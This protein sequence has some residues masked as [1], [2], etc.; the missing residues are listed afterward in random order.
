M[1]VLAAIFT[2]N[3]IIDF[4]KFVAPSFSSAAVELTP[5]QK[6]LL[7]VRDSG[8]LTLLY[9]KAKWS[10]KL[11]PRFWMKH[12][13]P[14]GFRCFHFRSWIQACH[15]ESIVYIYK[16]YINHHITII[17]PSSFSSHS[18]SG[19]STPYSPTQGIVTL[20]SSPILTSRFSPNQRYYVALIL[21]LVLVLVL[22]QV[23]KYPTGIWNIQ[24]WRNGNLMRSTCY[25]L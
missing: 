4:C 6:R 11:S 12:L 3:T 2:I 10:W 22:V 7:G 9:S 24:F 15:T 20:G 14:I 5:N 17:S 1:G 21:V 16:S 19:Q 13:V 25:W 23:G 18:I 8:N